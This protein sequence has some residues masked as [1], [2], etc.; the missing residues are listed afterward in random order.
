MRHRV[1]DL[2]HLPRPG[3]PKPHHEQLAVWKAI[4]PQRAH[5]NQSLIVVLLPR[6]VERAEH[7]AAVIGGFLEIAAAAQDQLLL[8]PTL[9]VAMGS[10]DDVVLMCH[11]AGVVA[12]AQVVVA[13]ECL[14]PGCDIQ[15][16]VAFRFASGGR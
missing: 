5:H 14:V 3:A 4:G 16:V 11:V 15:G 1:D 6:G 8:Q 9:H 2:V 10:L 7:L 12:G 13:A